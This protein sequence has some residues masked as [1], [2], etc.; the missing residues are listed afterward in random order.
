MNFGKMLKVFQYNILLQSGVPITPEQ[1]GLKPGDL[2]TPFSNYLNN[3]SGGGYGTIGTAGTIPTAPA[4]PEDPTDINAQ[5]Q[6]NEA[7]VSYN[8]QMAAYNQR[9]FTLMMQQFQRLQYQQRQV[10]SSGS[11][12][13]STTSFGGEI[14]EI[15]S[16]L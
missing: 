7:L 4:T 12:S 16:L 8:Q 10:G 3:V 14:P 11:S 1:A 2:P 6:F 5:K 9:L 13:S 15:G